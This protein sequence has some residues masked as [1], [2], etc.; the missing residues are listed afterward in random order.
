[1]CTERAYERLTELHAE[2]NVQEFVVTN[3]IPQTERFRALDFVSVRDLSNILA[4][5]INRIHYSR[6]VRDLFVTSE[7]TAIP[8]SSQG[9][10]KQ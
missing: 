3:T 7:P 8:F 2:Y 9:S 4:R 1:L 5:V 6:P 10:V